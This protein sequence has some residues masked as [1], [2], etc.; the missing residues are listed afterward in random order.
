MQRPYLTIP[1]Y[2]FTRIGR[3]HTIFPHQMLLPWSCLLLPWLLLLADQL[4]QQ[5]CT[6]TACSGTFPLAE[7]Y[8]TA[9]KNSESSEGTVAKPF[10]LYM[11]L[12]TNRWS[13]HSVAN[14]SV[15]WWF[16]PTRPSL[17]LSP[18]LQTSIFPSSPVSVP[19]HI[20]DACPED[21]RVPTSLW[22]VAMSIWWGDHGKALSR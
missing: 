17:L 7:Q 16:I 6:M 11:P 8:K 4:H 5:T 9:A 18:T 21:P 13:H 22:Q 2:D 1:L 3:H 19:R 15:A 14:V 12:T 10:L 20:N